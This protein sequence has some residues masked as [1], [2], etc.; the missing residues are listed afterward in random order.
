MSTTQ[1]DPYT[2]LG[3]QPGASV[4]EI[5]V[6]YRHA[7]RACHPD[8][9]HPDRDRLAT[10]ITAY[11]QLRDHND[12]DRSDDQNAQQRTDRGHLRDGHGSPGRRIPVRVHSDHTPPTTP[13]LRVGPVHHHPPPG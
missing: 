13:A 8:T 9:P 6:A 4:A 3:L 11:R 12:L 7:V 5:T 10:V 1:P 2:V